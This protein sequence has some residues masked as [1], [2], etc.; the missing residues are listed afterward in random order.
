M[1]ENKVTI[2]ITSAVAIGGK[3]MRPGTDEAT[4]LSVGEGLATNLFD[5]GK[6]VLSTADDD[7]D[8]KPKA[9]AK[10]KAGDKK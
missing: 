1:A 9:D 10:A 7:G 8:E 5:R 6:A 4:G 3:I 2:D